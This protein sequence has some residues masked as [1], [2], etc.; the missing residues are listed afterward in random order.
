LAP[1]KDIFKLVQEIFIAILKL[2][3]MLR[4]E[5]PQWI[6]GSFIFIYGEHILKKMSFM[7]WYKANI[8]VSKAVND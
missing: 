5:K 2:T 1:A 4:Q 7:K 3:M 6:S 8:P